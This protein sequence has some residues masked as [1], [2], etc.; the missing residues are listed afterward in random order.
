M[1]TRTI[2]LASSTTAA[3]IN[4]KLGMNFENVGGLDTQLDDIARRVLTSRAN[5]TAAKRLG[6]SYVRGIHRRGRTTH[7][8]IVC[9]RRTRIPRS[10][11]GIGIAFDHIG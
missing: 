5:P 10:R 2:P 3:G 1:T 8:G 9:L 7:T 11:R 4:K 6:I